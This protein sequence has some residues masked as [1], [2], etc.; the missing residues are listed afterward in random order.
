[1]HEITAQMMGRE[2]QTW[3]R[4]L[5]AL[6]SV[7]VLCEL[8]SLFSLSPDVSRRGER[9]EEKERECQRKELIYGSIFRVPAMDRPSNINQRNSASKVT[10]EMHPEDRRPDETDGQEGGQQATSK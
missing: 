2:D 10:H 5:I 8:C 4:G 6:S 3:R 9:R 1:M 7:Y